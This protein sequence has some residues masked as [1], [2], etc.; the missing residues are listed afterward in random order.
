LQTFDLDSFR[1]HFTALESIDFPQG[2]PG[3][4]LRGAFGSVFRKIACAPD[5]P[6]LSGGNV[7]E[8]ER[9]QSCAYARIFEP[10]S[11]GKGPSGLGDWPRPFVFRAAHLDGTT[12]APEKQF[13]FDVN[14]FDTR[15]APLKYFV[16]AFQQLAHA[17]LG[18][19]RG[20]AE[21]MSAEHLDRVSILLDDT[22]ADVRRLRIEFKTPTELKGGDRPEFGVLFARSRDRIS[23]LRALY[24]PG[25]LEIDFRGMG[26]R[27]NAIRM[28]RC[29]LRHVDAERR[30]SRT[31]QVHGIGGFVGVAEY[32]GDLGEFLPYLEAAR[33]TGVGRQ[34]VWGKGELRVELM[35]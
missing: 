10:A 17:G 20:R 19:R 5:C 15:D 30:S 18:P 8:C 21:L 31:G 33:W 6:G 1:F 26:E 35:G 7:R 4:I 28:T 22:P 3:N 2:K 14:L 23:T 32:D 16:P 27:A 29:E 9:R 13:W 25:P 12:A 34:C 24:G 11:I